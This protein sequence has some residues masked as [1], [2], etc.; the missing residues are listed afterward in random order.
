MS[1]CDAKSLALDVT[2]GPHLRKYKKELYAAHSS[3]HTLAHFAKINQSV[4]VSTVD[5]ITSFNF[6]HCLIR[7]ST[8]HRTK[9][10]S[11]DV[12]TA[13]SCKFGCLQPFILPQGSGVYVICHSKHETVVLHMLETPDEANWYISYDLLHSHLFQNRHTSK[14]TRATP[15]QSRP[16]AFRAE[17]QGGISLRHIIA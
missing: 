1:P 11:K 5:C 9:V 8:Y 17:L 13:A 10:E 4:S 12:W 2:F 15:D 3:K 7:L 6:F 14:R 16:Y